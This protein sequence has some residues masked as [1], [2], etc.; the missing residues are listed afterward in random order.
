MTTLTR[1]SKLQLLRHDLFFGSSG[2][3]VKKY[4]PQRHRAHR[5]FDL[6][7]VLS[8][9]AVSHT[10]AL[11]TFFYDSLLAARISCSKS[12]A[13]INISLTSLKHMEYFPL[14]VARTLYI[15]FL[16]FHDRKTILIRSDGKLLLEHAV[17]E[18]YVDRTDTVLPVDLFA[19][20][21][22]TAGIGNADL[23]DPAL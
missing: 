6:L 16:C 11:R 1:G 2:S 3:T 20:R 13:S 21:I 8:A 17:F 10:E 5:E 22:R 7:G 15:T 23:I 12:N 19:F 9:S 18:D 4:S 14:L